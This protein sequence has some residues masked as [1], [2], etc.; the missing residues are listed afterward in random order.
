MLASVVRR[1]IGASDPPTRDDLERT[2]II[3]GQAGIFAG[4]GLFSALGLGLLWLGGRAIA[5]MVQG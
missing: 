4:L 3:L 2:E 5:R 1:L